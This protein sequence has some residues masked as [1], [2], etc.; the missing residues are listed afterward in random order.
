[1]EQ[2]QNTVLNKTQVFLRSMFWFIIPSFSGV[3]LAWL[4]IR[5][6]QWIPLLIL[7]TVILFFIYRIENKKIKLPESLN[8]S[9]LFGSLIMTSMF[10][11]MFSVFIMIIAFLTALFYTAVQNNSTL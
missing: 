4:S 5:Y 8:K 9:L 2:S 1:M 11:A 3:Y 7:C 6:L 10:T